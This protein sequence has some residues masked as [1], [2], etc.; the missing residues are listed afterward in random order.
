M[1]GKKSQ[2]LR[3]ILNHAKHNRNV[4]LAGILVVILALVGGIS[5]AL[6]NKDSENTETSIQTNT[7]LSNSTSLEATL[8]IIEGTVQTRNS[9]SEEW[10]DADTNTA[11]TEG[12]NLRTV[13]ATSRVEI[14]AKGSLMR[15]DANSELTIETM[16]EDRTV[17]HLTDGYSYY[18]TT[19]DTQQ[20]TLVVKTSGAQ[21]ETKNAVFRAIYSGDEEAIEVFKGNVVET[22]ENTAITEG[23]KYTVVDRGQSSNNQK[24]KKL[25]INL[26]KNDDFITWNIEIDSKNPAFK[27]TLGFLSDTTEPVLEISSHRDGDIILIE[28]SATEASTVITGKSEKGSK[29]TITLKSQ[30]NSTE[31]AVT[32]DDTGN[33]TSN[34]VSIPIGSETLTIRAVDRVGNT[35]EKVYD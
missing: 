35:V 10:K 22:K 12:Q 29:L 31:Y 24:S 8:T 9:E 17:F 19:D 6:T 3:S 21:Y 18:R 23:N 33:F 5:A 14:T 26:L 34:P 15:L 13:G 20:S 7:A 30:S 27:N 1:S 2:R 28:P 16:T 11:I 25:D 32:V 4:W